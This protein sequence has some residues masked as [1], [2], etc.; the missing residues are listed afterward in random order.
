MVDMTGQ[1]SRNGSTCFSASFIV[2]N[3]EASVYE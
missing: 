2:K 1:L 3:T